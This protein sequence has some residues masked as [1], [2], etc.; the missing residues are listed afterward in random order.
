MSE[1]EPGGL[2]FALV[3]LVFGLPWLLGGA[4]AGAVLWHTTWRRRWWL[5][6]L[7]GAFLGATTGFFAMMP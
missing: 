3:A 2:Q 5:G 4:V 1:I 6:A 7:V